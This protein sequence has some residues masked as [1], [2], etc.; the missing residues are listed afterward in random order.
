M[1]KIFRAD[2]LIKVF[3][4]LPAK[5]FSNFGN[6]GFNIGKCGIGITMRPAHWLSDDVIIHAQLGEIL[7]R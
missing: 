3:R 5:S 4:S 6:R 7:R 2:C 1:L